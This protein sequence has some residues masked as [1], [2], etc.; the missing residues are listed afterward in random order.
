MTTT[1]PISVLGQEYLRVP[2]WDL[3]YSWPISMIPPST[4]P[5][6]LPTLPDKLTVLARLFTYDTAVYRVVANSEEQDQLQQ[7]LQRLLEWKKS[8]D[9]LFHPAKYV[10]MPITR[11]RSP[12]HHPYVLHGHNLDIVHTVNY[13]GVSLH[14]DMTWDTHIN[15]MVNKANQRLVFLRSNLKIS[16]S[17]I[18]EKSYKAFVRPLLKYAS[19]PP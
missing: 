16:S 11:S 4:P 19:Q 15:K 8:W 6:L 13:L 5:P 10:S 17:S 12:L 2:C 3:A 9:M 7:D 18:K 1:V 14:R